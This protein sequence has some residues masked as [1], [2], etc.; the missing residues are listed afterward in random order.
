MKYLKKEVV[1]RK[2]L[3]LSRE[4]LIMNQSLATC[5]S[6]SASED[7]SEIEEEEEVNEASVDHRKSMQTIEMKRARKQERDQI[8]GLF[9][10]AKFYEEIPSW[11]NPET[12][13][14][15]VKKIDDDIAPKLEADKEHVEGLQARTIDN[16]A[17]TNNGISI[18]PISE[19]EPPTNLQLQFQT[20]IMIDDV[21]L[22]KTMLA[23]AE[24]FSAPPLVRTIYRNCRQFLIRNEHQWHASD[25]VIKNCLP[26]NVV[27]KIEPHYVVTTPFMAAVSWGSLNVIDFFLQHEEVDPTRRV[28][29]KA[30]DGSWKHR[31]TSLHLA[32]HL[33]N[34]AMLGRLLT[35]RECS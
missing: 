25:S 24:T 27:A 21:E 17:A 6:E 26:Q 13:L 23:K 1:S 16:S 35:S 18:E 5:K 4:R 11:Y 29:V 33:G 10:E 14:L 9:S 8:R 34:A 30:L 20:A 32:A 12:S 19:G 31:Q 28:E 3:I 7:G 2:L 15:F 22:M